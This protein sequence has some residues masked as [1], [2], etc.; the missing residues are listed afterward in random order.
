M[1]PETARLGSSMRSCNPSPQRL[2]GSA[3]IHA[4]MESRSKHLTAPS[5]N[6]GEPLTEASTDGGAAAKCAEE[7]NSCLL[8]LLQ[9]IM[10]MSLLALQFGQRASNTIISG[11]SCSWFT[12]PNYVYPRRIEIRLHCGVYDKQEMNVGLFVGASRK[13]SSG[14]CER[15]SRYWSSEK[16]RSNE[17]SDCQSRERRET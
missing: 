12:L 5:G 7:V 6:P 17:A 9:T 11:E 16:S 10:S 8:N 4:L 15:R 14:Q 3:A 13:T 1:Q 2:D